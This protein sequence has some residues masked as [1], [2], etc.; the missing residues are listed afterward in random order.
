MSGNVESVK[1]AELVSNEL[2]LVSGGLSFNYST[3]EWTYVQQKSE[4]SEPTPKPS[5]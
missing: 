2:E 3:M 1:P 4:G 5:H